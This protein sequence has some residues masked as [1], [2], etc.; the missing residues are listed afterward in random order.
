M[1]RIQTKTTRRSKRLRTERWNVK[2][3]GKPHHKYTAGAARANAEY[4]IS[5]ILRQPDPYRRG[6]RK[7][8]NG[9]TGIPESTL[10]DWFDHLTA[11]EEWRPWL[12]HFRPTARI[13]TDAQEANM[14]AYIRANFID[15]K[16]VFTDSDFRTLA[17]QTYNETV[18]EMPPDEAEAFR[19]RHGFKCSP[20]YI[21]DF[22]KC[23]GF[24]S[25]RFH[26]KRRSAVTEQS[27]REWIGHMVKLLDDPSI[28]NDRIVNCDETAWLLCPRGIL[29]WHNTGETDVQVHI[30]GSEK[31]N[32]TVLASVTAAS[33]KLPLLF[34]AE[35]KTAAVHATQIGEIGYHWVDHS[36]SGWQIEDTFET[37]L[38][39]LREYMGVGPIHL[40]LDCYTAHNTGRIRKVAEQLGITLHYIPPGLTDELQP[41]DRKMFGV[42]KAKAKALFR[43]RLHDDP[44][45]KRTKRDG[46]ADM[47]RAWENLSNTVIEEAWSYGHDE[48]EFPGDGTE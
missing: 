19:H 16:L 6:F 44:S 7:E 25:R 20:G 10:K 45:A 9:L 23:H 43:R 17:F 1:G 3:L 41:L 14:A 36:E 35:G 28:P 33:T 48:E 13:F 15:A 38:V 31:D 24:S 5:M 12:P 26:Y 37:Y 47:I 40:V 21:A 2:P 27:K 39:H 18:N 22:K 29:T 30:Q 4:A 34:I 42:L 11:D 8:L 46:V 32:I